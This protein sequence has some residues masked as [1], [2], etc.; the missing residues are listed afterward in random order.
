[1]FAGFGFSTSRPVDPPEFIP[2]LTRDGDD[3]SLGFSHSLD[4]FSVGCAPYLVQRSLQGFFRMCDIA[5]RTNEVCR[6]GKNYLRSVKNAVVCLKLMEFRLN[7]LVSLWHD[8]C[9]NSEH[10]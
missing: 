3:T 8:K 7:R 2:C 1:M 9:R 10:E 5:L 6:G 4:A